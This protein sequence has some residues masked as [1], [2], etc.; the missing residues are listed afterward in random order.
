MKASTKALIAICVI[1]AVAIAA[2]AS[3]YVISR[4]GRKG[5]LTIYCAGSLGIPFSKLASIYTSKYGVKVRI[6]TH[7]SVEVVRLVTSLGKICDVVGV[8]DYRL[9]PYFMVP[10]YADWYV[11]FATNQ[12]VLVFTNKSRYASWLEKHPGKWYEVLGMPG[13]RYG[14]SNPD[15]DPCGYR[16]V[17]VLALASLYYHNESIL[18]DYVLSKISGAR[19]KL[20][21]GTLNVYIPATFSIKGNLVIKPKEVD[22]IALLESGAIDYAFEY[23]SLAKQH[24]LRYV[25]LPVKINLSSPKYDRYYSRVVVHILVG[26]SKEKAIKMKSIV[27]GVTIP[28]NAPHKSLALKFVELLLSGVGRKVFEEEGQPFLKHPI[29]FGNVPEG[30]RKYVV[31]EKG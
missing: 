28:K 21:N 11:A 24:H 2:S 27:Y 17:G 16:A 4:S 22:L 14:F 25:K 15:M 7:G 8:A 26:S 5:V 3:Y 23:L 20:V 6:E 12:L 19:A 13:V 30:L 9:I 1:V 10:K 29:G 18:K 31:F